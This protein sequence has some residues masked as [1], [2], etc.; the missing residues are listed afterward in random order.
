[1]NA[2]TVTSLAKKYD[3]F[4][5]LLP[6]GVWEVVDRVTFDPD[7]ESSFCIT[8]HGDTIAEAT[9]DLLQQLAEVAVR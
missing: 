1:M 8:G 2:A 4:P 3:I 5:Y 6:N 7:P 9:T